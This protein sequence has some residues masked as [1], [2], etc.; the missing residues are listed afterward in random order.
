MKIE[1]SIHNPCTY[2]NDD[3]PRCKTNTH[4]ADVGVMNNLGECSAGHK[5]SICKE[6]SFFREI[7]NDFN[8]GLKEWEDNIK[9]LLK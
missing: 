6:E 9:E 1:N 4:T 2:G 7:E 5:C 3:C 8:D